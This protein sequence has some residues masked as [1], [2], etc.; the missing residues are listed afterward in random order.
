MSCS[1]R[2]QTCTFV[3]PPVKRR[4]S[5][6]TQPSRTQPDVLPSSP[7]LE[8]VDADGGSNTVIGILNGADISNGTQTY[9]WDHGVGS[10]STGLPGDWAV[11]H[12]PQNNNANQTSPLTA[13][14]GFPVSRKP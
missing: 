14:E 4:R 6:D 12:S 1:S 11:N 13:L 10:T 7:P 9:G 8:A 3:A 5:N 2:R